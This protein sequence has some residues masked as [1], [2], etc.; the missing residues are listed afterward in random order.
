MYDILQLNDMLLT[1]LL[2]VAEQ[3]KVPNA[4][5]F[6]KPDL[7]YKILDQQ[8]VINT[9]STNSADDDG[10]TKRKRIIKCLGNM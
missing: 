10:K 9:P 1:E 5:K 3:L 7:I 4:K 6:E 2:D 8:A